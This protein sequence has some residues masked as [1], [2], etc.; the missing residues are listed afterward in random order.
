MDNNAPLPALRRKSDTDSQLTSPASAAS[1]LYD[2]VPR[3]HSEK[4]DEG[5]KI[6]STEG[7]TFL[8]GSDH[9][10]HAQHAFE[11]VPCR[12]TSCKKF[13]GDAVL[14]VLQLLLVIPF[15]CLGIIVLAQ[16]GKTTAEVKWIHHITAAISYGPTIFPILFSLIIG[17]LMKAALRWRL[18]RRTTV[19]TIEQLHGSRTVTSAIITQVKLQSFN[20]LAI[21]IILLWALSPVGSQAALR[22]AAIVPVVNNVGFNL[23]YLDVRNQFDSRLAGVSRSLTTGLFTTSILMSQSEEGWD[24]WGNTKIPMIESLEGS[25]PSLEWISTEGRNVSYASLIGIP[26]MI[27]STLAAAE[28][29]TDVSFSLDTSYWW[30]NCSTQQVTNDSW[31]FPDPELASESM[32]S[33]LASHGFKNFKDGSTRMA[34]GLPYDRVAASTDPNDITWLPINDTTAES[35]PLFDW[36]PRRLDLIA[37]NTLKIGSRFAARCNMTTTFVTINATCSGAAASQPLSASRPLQRCRPTAI[38]RSQLNATRSTVTILD[39]LRIGRNNTG[40]AVEFLQDF[41]DASP[42]EVTPAASL[43]VGYLANPRSPGSF[44]TDFPDW[45]AVSARDFSMRFA[46]LLNTYWVAS[47]G[48][49]PVQGNFDRG[50]AQAETGGLGGVFNYVDGGLGAAGIPHEALKTDTTWT[51]VLLLASAVLLSAAATTLVLN[52][53]RKTPSGIENFSSLL[54]DT[55]HAQ[56][57]SAGQKWPLTT[58]SMLD[59]FERSRLLKDVVV[60]VG[61]VAPAA[62]YGYI[63]LGTPETVE[64]EKLKKGRKYM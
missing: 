39:F 58:S 34:W 16:D 60:Q 44:E 10:G 7:S 8:D 53:R 23:T 22:I 46:R 47:V 6:S 35:M 29:T 25:T 38:R 18:E 41:V 51:A 2:Q 14:D 48:Y 19:E 4:Q 52:V 49:K 17:R 42:A 62:P 15:V 61:D 37:N 56:V 33:Q 3:G 57:M 26:A 1:P 21:G 11:P 63:A 24:A 54:R 5:A 50:M 45:S 31:V 59:G 13:W 36:K 9:G 43:H 64:M 20:L 28:G 55:P 30:L 12:N 32:R 27:N 40:R